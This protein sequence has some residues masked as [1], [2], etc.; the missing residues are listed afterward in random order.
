MQHGK[1]EEISVLIKAVR[2]FIIIK[3]IMLPHHIRINDI[4][5]IIISY[6]NFNRFI[7]KH[8]HVRK[9]RCLA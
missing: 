3:Q 8:P 4:Q 2:C 7:S 5:F 9:S 1:F 6:I